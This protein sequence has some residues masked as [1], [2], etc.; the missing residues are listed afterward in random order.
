MSTPPITIRSDATLITAARLMVERNVTHLPVVDTENRLLGI[1]SRGDIIGAFLVS[2]EHLRHLI[3]HDIILGTMWINPQLVNVQVKDG[4][5]TLSGHLER[6]SLVPP[7]IELTSMADGV[8]DVINHLT[9]ERDDTK[10][11]PIP[12]N[13]AFPR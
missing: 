13:P 4:V 12:P 5:V 8:V 9:Y 1:V 7:T 11:P 10:I 2:D 6:K 3:E